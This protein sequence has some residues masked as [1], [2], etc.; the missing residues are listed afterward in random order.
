MV[1]DSLQ[2][3]DALQDGLNRGLEMFRANPVPIAL[4][5]AGAAWLIASNTG[6]VDRL[7]NDDRIDAARRRVTDLASDIGN[8]AG[9]LAST[10][11]ERVGFAG[12]GERALGHT[13]NP[14]VDHS[15]DRRGSDGWVHQVT[16]MAQGALRSARDSGE[17]ILN[18]AGSYTGAT[19]IADRFADAFTRHPLVIGAVGVMGG[20]LLAAMLPATRVE[21]EVLGST[22]DEL[23]QKAEQVSQ[24]AVSRVKEVALRAADA[25]ADAAA[26]TVKSVTDDSSKA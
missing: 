14:V 7:A 9:E 8:R 3:P 17:A 25:A 4:I 18:R 2:R 24:D 15:G 23:W 5:G 6:I 10:V 13:G 21:D 22:R 19:S 16:D 20:A 12:E 11:A 26:E 1:K